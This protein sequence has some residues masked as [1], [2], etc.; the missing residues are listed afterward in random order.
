MF[1][2]II[3]QAGDQAIVLNERKFP[4]AAVYALD[5][6]LGDDLP[7]HRHLLGDA[8]HMAL[9]VP[10]LHLEA[11]LGQFPLHLRTAQNGQR[12]LLEPADDLGRRLRRRQQ[13]RKVSNTKSL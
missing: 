10:R 11:Q 7:E 8:R 12:L 13:R 1:R 2:E 3:T 6:G 9:A 5:A 4:R